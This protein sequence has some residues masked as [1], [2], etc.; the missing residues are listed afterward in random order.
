IDRFGINSQ[1]SQIAYDPVQS[2]L[3]VGTNDSKFGPGQIYV[4]GQKRVGVILELPRRASVKILQF[5]A[6][7]LL[8]LDSR[9]DFSIYQLEAKRLIASHSPPGTVTAL[10]SDPTLDYAMLGMQNGDVLAYDLDRENIAPF[11]IPNLWK[12]ENPRAGMTPVV[13]L[14]FN[15]RDIGKL[16]IGYKEGAVTY[17]FKQAKAQ[18]Y[19]KYE[20]PRGAPGGD[21]D[22][23]MA[24]V[25]RHPMLTQ[26]VWHP[27]G[28]FILTG[29][30]DGSLVFWDA[31]DGR[32]LMARSLDATNINQPGTGRAPTGASSGAVTVKEPLSKI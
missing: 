31:K 2:L 9:N 6:D 8:C 24:N 10:H 15:P 25:V 3:A 7:K 21:D 5:C 4:F 11:R 14:A 32:L 17:T 1:V 18:R 29:H 22:P 30:E 16:L 12:E 19:F 26:A 28:T 27:N 20:V 13:S 23:S